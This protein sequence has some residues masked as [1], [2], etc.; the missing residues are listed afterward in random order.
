M[1]PNNVSSS[2]ASALPSMFLFSIS[3][4]LPKSETWE[5]SLTPAFLLPLNYAQ[6]L[7][8]LFPKHLNPSIPLLPQAIALI[9]VTLPT[10]HPNYY[11]MCSTGLTASSLAPFNYLPLWRL[12]KSNHITPPV[13]PALLSLRQNLN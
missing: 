4:Q 10:T 5:S 8:F 1:S 9:Q 11:R 7:Q 13:K 3:I 12:E 2:S 6:V